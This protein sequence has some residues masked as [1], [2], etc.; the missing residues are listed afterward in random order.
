MEIY[1]FKVK[2]YTTTLVGQ[3][4]EEEGYFYIQRGDGEIMAKYDAVTEF[5]RI[6][7]SKKIYSEPREEHSM[8]TT[9]SFIGKLQSI[10]ADK[11]KLPLVID[12]P[13]GLEVYPSIK[14]RTKDNIPIIADGEVDKMVI[15]WQ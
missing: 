9:D 2:D 4:N 15:T 14:M 7:W 6:E 1:L 3:Y 11:R 12:C 5:S 10:S 8:D 13:N